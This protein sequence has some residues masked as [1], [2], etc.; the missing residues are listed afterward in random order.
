[1]NIDPTT[2][3]HKADGTYAY[4]NYTDTDIANPVN[5]IEQT[6]NTWTSNRIVGS[7]YADVKFNSQFSFRSTFGLDQ[8]FSLQNIFYPK[9]DL[10][11]IPEISEA[12]P[13]EKKVDQQC[14]SW[15]LPMAQP[16]MGKCIDL[17]KHL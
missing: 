14:S 8:T 10:S 11:N 7:V 16:A 3:I 13:A 15:K 1:L 9:F 17:P 2:P 12:P 5:G 4:S 6:Y